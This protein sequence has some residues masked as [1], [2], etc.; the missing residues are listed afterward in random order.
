M[1]KQANYIF[2]KSG[3]IQSW[4]DWVLYLQDLTD[5]DF[6]EAQDHFEFSFKNGHYEI[7]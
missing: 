2:K 4:L 7:V 3:R 5:C 1:N 6:Y